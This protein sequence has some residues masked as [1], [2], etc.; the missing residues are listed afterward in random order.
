[1]TATLYTTIPSTTTII[2]TTI[3]ITVTVTVSSSATI[4]YSDFGSSAR[5]KRSESR[6]SEGRAAVLSEFAVLPTES[7]PAVA[8]CWAQGTSRFSAQES[9]GVY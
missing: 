6:G 3:L 7:T 1:V 8:A 4:N 5:E 9:A 2:L